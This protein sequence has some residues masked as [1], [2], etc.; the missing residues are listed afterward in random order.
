MRGRIKKHIKRIGLALTGLMCGTTCAF[1]V[2]AEEP[3]RN[4]IIADSVTEVA[5]YQYYDKTALESVY[6]PQSVQKIGVSAFDGCGSLQNVQ[7]QEGLSV[8]DN[9]S[10]ALCQSLAQIA[11]PNTVT[12]LGNAAFYGCS[13]LQAVRLPMHLNMIE[14]NVFY[15]CASLSNIVIPDS[16]TAIGQQS[17]YQCRALTNVTLPNRLTSIGE[18]AFYDCT[19]LR[20]INIPDSVSSIGNAAFAGCSQLVI[21]CNPGSYAEQY[22]KAAGLAVNTGQP[23]LMIAQNKPENNTVPAQPTQ[24]T[25]KTPT[26]M[27]P[28]VVIPKTGVERPY[29]LCFGAMVVAG[30]VLYQV[31]AKEKDIYK[32]DH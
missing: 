18:G 21:S 24:D 23:T 5:K 11:L 1:F 31:K 20:S 19:N 2:M 8:V 27:T 14:N 29:L 22:A 25:P 6:V 9:R 4:L 7:L 10:F 13:N 12:R 3:L 26:V 16:V 28:A 17:F 32:Y 30:F 15:Q